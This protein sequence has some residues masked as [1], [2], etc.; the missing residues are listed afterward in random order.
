MSYYNIKSAPIS[1]GQLNNLGLSVGNTSNP[2]PNNEF[3]E[4]E[5]AV[6]LDVILDE[7]HPELFSKRHLVD[8][9][10]VPANYKNEIPSTKDIDYTY[11]GACKVRLCFSQQGIEKE[12]LSWAFPL[13]STG[14]VEYPLLNEVVIVVKYF[15]K[16]FYTRKL[17]LNGFINQESNFR[18]EKFYGN[19]DGNKNLVSDEGLKTESIEGPSSLNSHKKI[20][21]NQVKGVL[22]SYFL[23][24]SKIRKLRRFEGDTVVESRHGQSIRFSAYDENRDND[25]GSYPDYKGDPTVNKPVEGCGNP[26]ILIRNRQRKLSLDKPIPGL[27]N[28]PSI[29]SIK[30]YQKNV[31]GL[32]DEDI[33]HDGTSIHI[34]SGLTKTKWRTTCYKSMFQSG[35]EEQP[36]FSPDGSTAFKFDITNLN[37]DQIVINSDR[38]IFSSRYAE[39]FHFSK[40]RYAI[41]TD[42]EYTVDAHDQIVLTTNNKTVLN[43]PAIYLGQYGQTNEPVLLGQTTVDWLYDLCNWLLDHVHWYNHVHDRSPGPTPDK[44]QESVQDQQ[45]KSLRDKLD[46]LLSR[47]VFVVGG[48]YAPGMDGVNPEGSSNLTDPISVNIVSG[49]GLPGEFKGRVRREGPVEVQFDEEGD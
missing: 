29:P 24:N 44:T 4:L 23:S 26:M 49:E 8:I 22:G 7:Y 38:L 15:D 1:F 48:G 2:T 32:I 47:R 9:R 13:E 17:N 34:T 37:G 43:S 20:A 3:Y 16:L 41:V 12:K 40:Q 21:N 25:K 5:P 14:V 33:N 42:S 39:T 30:D 45:L 46:S 28:L 18:L 27:F 10:N 19:N 36:L 11:I 6:V 35:A 31:G